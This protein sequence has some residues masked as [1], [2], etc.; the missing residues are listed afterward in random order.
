MVRYKRSG[1]VIRM[2][3]EFRDAV[4][5]TLELAP[6]KLSMLI[7][8]AEEDKRKVIASMK[9]ILLDLETELA[10]DNMVE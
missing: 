6:N 10:A 8:S 3:Q 4:G 1:P 9:V 2:P 7:Y 5:D